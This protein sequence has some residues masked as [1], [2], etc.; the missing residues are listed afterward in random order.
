V[1]SFPRQIPAGGEG[2]VQLKVNTNG[3]G[4]HQFK[5]TATVQSNDPQRPEFQL[6]ISG[7]VEPFAEITP[8]R[9]VFR[10]Y[11]GQP[12]RERVTVRMRPEHPFRL[13]GVEAKSGVNIKVTW[14]TQETPGGP[15]YVVE[16]ENL[17]KSEGKYYDQVLLKTDSAFKPLIPIHV[18]GTIAAAADR[19]AN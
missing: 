5:K 2:T 12:L 10:G 1:V 13:T 14:T 15:V 18:Y 7:F 3:Y 8:E 6:T 16:V 4:G 9:I 17:K 11:A 19:P